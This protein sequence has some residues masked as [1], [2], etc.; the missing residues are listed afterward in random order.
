VALPTSSDGS[1]EVSRVWKKFRR[2]RS[3]PFLADQLR[4]VTN[5][6]ARGDAWRWVLRDVDFSVAPGEAVA[7]VGS[8]GA[9]K[10]TLL[11]VLTRV[12][13]PSVG[14]VTINGR[15]G[16][17]IEL[18][19]GLHPDLSG[20][21]NI[22]M[23]GA[24]LGLTRT[25]IRQRFD[26]IVEFAEVGPAI[27]R[28]L[29]YYSSG[30]QMRLGFAIAAFLRPS[31]L[32]VDEVLAV[33]DAWFQQRCLDRMREVLNEGT[34]LMLVSHDLASIEATCTRALWLRDGVLV[35]DGPTRPVLA[36]YRKSVEEIS[37]E[38]Y[39]LPAKGVALV[40]CTVRAADTEIPISHG[41]IDVL[42]TLD[43]SIAITGR[44][45]LGIS[46]GSATPMLLVSTGVQF[47]QERVEIRC[48]M[49]DLPLPRGRYSVWL[50]LEDTHDDDIIPWHPAASFILAGTDLDPSPTAVVR[51][52]PVHLRADW[53]RETQPLPVTS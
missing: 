39:E 51:L 18:R 35:Q 50:Y 25:E 49:H 44:M 23:Y 30:M 46:E 42:V 2:D 16:A 26:T 3:Q 27:D 45:H 15:V 31:V 29:K 12:M 13:Y 38:G 28:S 20:R 5:R 37:L 10:S 11:K 21:E 19:G 34:T 6:V 9:G 1:I 43:S 36:E 22:Y 24:L 14:T 48:R 52:S 40:S 17:I 32:L 53:V 7:V 33:G 8:N 47:G 41:D 4:G